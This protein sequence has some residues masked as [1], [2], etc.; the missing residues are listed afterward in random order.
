MEDSDISNILIN[1]KSHKN[2]LIYN[3]SYKTLID[4]KLLRIRFSKIDR[5]IRI[6]DGFRYLTLFDTEIYVAI[7]NRIRYLMSLKSAI[8][9]IFCYSLA[10]VK[11]D[12]CDSLPIEKILTLYNVITHIKSDNHIKSLLP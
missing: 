1:E 12:S 10:K 8:T 11:A 4:P 7:Y 3:I 9:Y 6:Y 2:I 5:F